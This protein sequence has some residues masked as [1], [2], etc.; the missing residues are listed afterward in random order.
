MAETP[1]SM[2]TRK[3]EAASD[4]IRFLSRRAAR[5]ICAIGRV[6]VCRVGTRSMVV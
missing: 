4:A 1:S 6:R 2:S 3:L 5:S